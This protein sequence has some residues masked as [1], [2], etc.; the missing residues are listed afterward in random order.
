MAQDL[1][2]KRRECDNLREQIRKAKEERARESKGDALLAQ[3]SA[4]AKNEYQFHRKRLLEGH[5]GKI[6]A[7]HFHQNSPDASSDKLVSAAQDGKLMIWNANTKAKQVAI[8]MKSSW[9]MTCA[10]SPSARFVA[11]GG[12]DNICSV[13]SISA[14]DQGFVD[15]KPTAELQRH[16]GYLSCCRFL[17]DRQCLTSSGDATIIHWDIERK[18]SLNIFDR[19]GG[20]V[21]SLAINPDNPNIFLSGACDA[22]AKLWDIRE[23]GCVG[24]FEGHDSDINTVAW[25]PDGNAL[26][27]GSD[28]ST[29]RMFD[30]R[31]YGQIQKFDSPQLYCGVMSIDFSKSGNFIFAGY[32]D[33]PYCLVWDTTSPGQWK[34][35]MKH[36]NRVSCLQVNKDGTALGTGCW[37]FTIGIWT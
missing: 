13:Y 23:G 24:T 7:M 15:K 17:D 18:E 4:G 19:H 34:Q 3:V 30:K 6:Y 35:T 20:D 32:D 22:T 8:P 9:V 5:Y 26:G 12:L 25:F 33:E 29:I 37:D 28:D 21:M 2:A 16:E 36:G 1:Q 27:S 14:G 10:F 11:C 31:S